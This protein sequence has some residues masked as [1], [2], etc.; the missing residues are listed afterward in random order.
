MSNKLPEVKLYSDGWARPNP[1]KG[2]YG[3]I[4]E[5]GEIKKEF[6]WYEENTT[7]NRME[8]TWI[9]KWLEKLKIK[10]RVE[11]FTDSSYVVLGI[12]NWRAKK[13]ESQGWM[14]NRSKKAL[15]HDLR[16]K[17]LYLIE[18]HEVSF[19]WIKWHNWHKQNERCDELVTNQIMKNTWILKRDKKVKIE[20][21]FQEKTSKTKIKKPWD[22][23]RKCSSE[24][25]KLYPKKI[26]TKNKSYYYR[27]YL[28]CPNCKTNYF[29]EEAKVMI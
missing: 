7:N 13:W 8:L 5:Y 4:L 29:L 15:N 1:W 24:V 14:I 19:N 18:K 20:E 17:L 11:I 6:S 3:I 2:W 26:N 25:I 27:Y 23:C 28:S 9:I 16:E 22:K 21:K 12:K 10:S